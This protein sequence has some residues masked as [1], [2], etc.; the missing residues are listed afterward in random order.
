MNLTPLQKSDRAFVWLARDFAEEER[1]E[2]FAAR[3]KTVEIAKQ[4]EAAFNAARN[5][6]STSKGG[7]SI[8]KVKWA[9]RCTSISLTLTG[10]A[11]CP[12]AAVLAA[13]SLDLHSR[14]F[15]LPVCRAIGAGLRRSSCCRFLLLG[16]FSG[17]QC[18]GES[19]SPTFAVVLVSELLNIFEFQNFRFFLF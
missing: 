9:I 2:K 16:R 12:S 8:H 6:A 11:I 13:S 15:D 5:A 4:F 3:F 10:A 7:W 18:T 17:R 1:V 14:L 19:N